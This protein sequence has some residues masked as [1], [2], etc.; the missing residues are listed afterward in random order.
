MIRHPAQTTS[1]HRLPFAVRCEASPEGSLSVGSKKLSVSVAQAIRRDGADQMWEFFLVLGQ[2]GIDGDLKTRVLLCNPD[3][4]DP[5]ELA[6]I[7]SNREGLK[8][9]LGRDYSRPS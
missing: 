5:V 8:V 3:W 7:E 1:I 9:E 6:C 2:Q 4:D